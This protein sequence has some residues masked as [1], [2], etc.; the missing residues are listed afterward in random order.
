[1]NLSIRRAKRDSAIAYLILAASL[2][3][4]VLQ[5]RSLYVVPVA[6]SVRWGG[7][8]TWLMREFGNQAAHG[9]MAYPEHFGNATRTDGVLAGSMWVNALIYGVTGHVFFP[10]HDFAAIGRTVTA[11]LGLIL[12]LS[13]FLILRRLETRPVIAACAV[14]L[15]TI[16][17]G[18]AWATHCA[19]YDLLTGLVLLGYVYFLARQSET[20]MN[21][22]RAFWTGFTAIGL[23]IFSRHM[24]TLPAGA[25]LAF[26]LSVKLW[27]DRRILSSWLLG[28]LSAATTLSLAY[29]LGAGE[30]SLFGRGGSMGS[31]SFVLQQIPIAR[32][33]SRNVQISNLIE[34]YNLFAGDAPGVLLLAAVAI[35]LAISY[36][37]WQWRMR[38]HGRQ[39]RL[40][41]APAQTFAMLATVFCII[42]WCLFQGS[43]P[44]YLFHIT[45]LVIACGA[46]VLELFAEVHTA[47]WFGSSGA[48]AVLVAGIG[49]QASHAIPATAFGAAV[50][51]DQSA[52]IRRLLEEAPPKSRI[53][54]DVAGLN[55]ALMDTTHQILTLDMFQPPPTAEDA[56]SKLRANKI[57]FVILRSSPVGTP[58]EPGRSLLPHVLDSIGGARDTMLGFFYDDGRNYD[59]SLD[60]LI[61]QGLDTLKLY[62]APR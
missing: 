60:R 49:M 17:Q 20:Q 61:E 43:R 57:D 48:I 36:M 41:M 5:L 21:T 22:R 34:R 4:Y 62:S 29:W 7:D 14:A 50:V 45:P 59:A 24:L 42:G 23:L 19:R 40:A 11:I 3:I 33:F 46:I 35:I 58:F 44:Y 25:T 54:V 31:F 10:A 52:A 27:R 32:P 56:V 15:L 16:S 38:R 39:L 6:D 37:V 8:E 1:M 28:V 51:R 18:F 2:A 9:V 13:L 53:L 55:F 26:I 30:F 12:I 47:R